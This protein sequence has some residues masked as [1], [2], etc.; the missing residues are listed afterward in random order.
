MLI[1]IIYSI[2]SS[3]FILAGTHF[4]IKC[5][6]YI[7]KEIVSTALCDISLLGIYLLWIS[8]CI[9]LPFFIYYFIL[10][11][12]LKGDNNLSF[13]IN[14]TLNVIMLIPT[15]LYCLLVKNPFS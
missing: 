8:I 14:A 1:I 12:F 15:I 5:Y 9:V 13:I 4:L 11:S 7:K 10:N 3:I 2:V 6:G